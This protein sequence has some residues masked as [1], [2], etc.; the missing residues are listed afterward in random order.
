[1]S[2]L[3]TTP[4]KVHTCHR[5]RTVVLT[6]WAEG[7]H[8]R[9]DPTPLNRAGIIAAI[10]TTRTIYR[11]TRT[12]L[13]HLDQERIKSANRAPVLPEHHCGN[14]TPTEH[15]ATTTDDTTETTEE[16]IPF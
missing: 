1:M 12:G 16:V 2:H 6:G 4:V 13:I 8:T 3:H 9:A 15:H 11:L 5:C 10:L 14:P 7:L